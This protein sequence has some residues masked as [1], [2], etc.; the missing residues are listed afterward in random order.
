MNRILGLMHRTAALLF[1]PKLVPAPVRLG[2]GP[3]AF[4]GLVLMSQDRETVDVE[5]RRSGDGGQRERADAPGRRQRDDAGSSGG[6]GG[7]GG[8][9]QPPSFGGG[10]GGGGGGQLPIGDII[11]LLLRL[12]R[13]ILFGLIAIA[14][15]LGVA[16]V[17]FIGPNMTLP[18]D[19]GSVPPPFSQ[20]AAP[21][22]NQPPTDSALPPFSQPPTSGV[23]VPSGPTRTVSTPAASAGG[24]KWLVMLYQD[25]KDKVLDQDIFTDMNEAE[26][27]GSTDRVRIVAQIDRTRNSQNAREWGTAKRF[28]LTRDADLHTVHS[29]QLAD[30]GQVNM[31]DTKTLIDFVTWAVKAYPSDKYVLIMSDHGMGWPGGWTDPAVAASSS[32]T[33]R[34]VPLA[35]AVG[36]LMFL[37]DIDTAL[38][39][40]RSQAGVDKFELIG[41]D[42][43]LMSQMEVLTALAPHAR[44]AVA[45]EE[46]EPALGWAYTGFLDTL[47]ANPDITGADLARSIV[48]TYIV[49]D[50]RIVDDQAR[51]EFVSRGSALGGLFGGGSVPSAS[52]VASEMG[53]DVTLT[54]VDLQA[55]GNLSKALNNFA[56]VLQS[57]D[58][59]S[60]SQ[61]RSYAQS[62][63]SIFGKDVPASYIDLG[64]WTDLLTRQTVNN[65]AVTGAAQQLQTALKATV[66]AEKHGPGRPGST[67]ISIYFPNSQ[68]YGN[69]AAGAQSY[70]A[71][72]N[73]FANESLWDDF[74][75]YFYTGKKFQ[76]TTGTVAVPARG[77]TLTA[78]S[79]GGIQVTGLALSAKSVAVGKT[80]SVTADVD[81][82]NV[83]YVKLFVGFYDK[84]ANSIQVADEDFLQSS[85][86]RQVA[87]VYYPVWPAS[88]KFTVRFK[89]E[90]V[91]FAINDGKKNVPVLFTPETYGASPAD[92]IYTVEGVYNFADGT[93]QPARLYFR[94]KILRQVFGFTTGGGAGAP[95]EITTKPG[96]T[97]TLLDNWIDLDARGNVVKTATQKGATLTF[98]D[99][100]FRWK[101]LD[102][103]AGDYMVGY[104]VEDLD[105]NATRVFAPITVQ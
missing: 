48:K 35:S 92:A 49:S 64:N 80:V 73:R 84:A 47:A 94:D 9:F 30:L 1:P 34:G 18:S 2:R 17:F 26:R 86:T 16:Y 93:S 4:P 19:T 53:Q 74:L 52:Q 32:A 6:G 12:P 11:G 68:L 5:R 79:A 83:G 89:W 87:G 95:R 96:D 62:Y 33:N 10:G 69:P 75:A 65:S 45:S 57:A 42:A 72:A 88:G 38:G 82:A 36:N 22:F 28:F 76:P 27:T 43:C 8:G 50:Q 44:Y 46:T 41:M 102:A 23:V 78:P 99:Q 56:F 100:P 97:F 3:H 37:N 14:C 66:L 71:I 13:P 103:A 20:P 58:Q 21:P 85:Q 101:D 31:A 91:V 98:G 51:A 70:T 61:A 90:P 40:I 55:F 63:T 24:P 54:A 7:G 59:H 67:G 29:Q 104:T 15:C 105:G 39:T 25:A 77:T 81:G 60:I